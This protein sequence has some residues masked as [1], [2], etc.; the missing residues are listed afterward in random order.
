MSFFSFLSICKKY[1]EITNI[2]KTS[3]KNT[4]ELV[5]LI[6]YVQTSQDYTIHKIIEEIEDACDRLSFL[7]DYATQ[8]GIWY[9]KINEIA[10][11][12]PKCELFFGY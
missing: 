7:M 6:Q 10:Y 1:E 3:P 11:N 4:E 2:A 9:Y 5:T 12:I 8:S